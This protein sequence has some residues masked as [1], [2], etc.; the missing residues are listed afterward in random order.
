MVES[1]SQY[2]CRGPMGNKLVLGAE[3][4]KGSRMKNSSYL[5]RPEEGTAQNVPE[6]RIVRGLTWLNHVL[7][8]CPGQVTQCL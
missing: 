5:G 2:V 6:S 4:Q 8:L 1:Q 3:A 7:A